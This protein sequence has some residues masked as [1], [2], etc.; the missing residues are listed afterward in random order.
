VKLKEANGRIIELGDSYFGL[1]L[2]DFARLGANCVTQP[3]THIGP[4]TWVY[5]MT[6]VRGFIPREKRVFHP[7]AV[8]MTDNG[9]VDLK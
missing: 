2:G 1:I 5:P 8:E 3:G 9:I 7:Q 6:N 4:Y